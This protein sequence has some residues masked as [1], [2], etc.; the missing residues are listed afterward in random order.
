[1]AA[2][3]VA[4]KTAFQRAVIT[5]FPGGRLGHWNYPEVLKSTELLD[6]YRILPLVRVCCVTNKKKRQEFL[7]KAKEAEAKAEAAQGL[8]AKE[9][10]SKVAEIYREMARLE[11]GTSK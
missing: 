5:D 11:R 1:M 3:K 10:W 9:A 6:H 8:A 7:A 4:A 2:A